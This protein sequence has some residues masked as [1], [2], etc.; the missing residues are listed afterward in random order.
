MLYIDL[1][2]LRNPIWSPIISIDS[3][4]I[5]LI[6]IKNRITFTEF[7]R[8][9]WNKI[10]IAVDFHTLLFCVIFIQQTIAMNSRDSTDW[11]IRSFTSYIFT[12]QFIILCDGFWC[13]YV[14]VQLV[15]THYPIEVY[16]YSLCYKRAEWYECVQAIHTFGHISWAQKFE[17][18]FW[19]WQ[20]LRQMDDDRC[21]DN[22]GMEL[23][24]KLKDVGQ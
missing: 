21:N 8:R 6:L 13:I 9:E 22:F 3:W 23:C 17:I 20:H 24:W 15:A 16:V 18:H 7:G 5:H 11:F 12:S 19:I 10:G 1:K 4:K 14:W 2:S